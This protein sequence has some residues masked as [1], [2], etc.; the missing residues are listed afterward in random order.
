M[1]VNIFTLNPQS[2][3]L[4]QILICIYCLCYLSLG[5]LS[6]YHVDSQQQSHRFTYKAA[7]ISS[8]AYDSINQRVFFG[9]YDKIIFIYY[10]EGVRILP[11]EAATPKPLPGAR[12]AL[13]ALDAA[14]AATAATAT[15]ISTPS[16][17]GDPSGAVVVSTTPVLSPPSTPVTATESSSSSSP[18]SSS[19]STSI[20]LSIP[21]ERKDGKIELPRFLHRLTGHTSSIRC[22][23]YCGRH[24]LLL[25]GSMDNSIAVWSIPPPGKV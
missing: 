23:A 11:R 10:L 25:S 12:E 5:T 1:L 16:G 22:L 6:A 17:L 2:I 19:T 14:A 7:R 21:S 8:V 4:L 20:S 3:P 13:A 18:A 24:S 9:T 15:D